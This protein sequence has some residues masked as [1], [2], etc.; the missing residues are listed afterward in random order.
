MRDGSGAEVLVS[1]GG[2]TRRFAVVLA[3]GF[4]SAVPPWVHVGLGKEDAADVE[5]HW[6]GGKVQ[7]LQHL[8]AGSRWTVSEDSQV[9]RQTPFV[10]RADPQR[11]LPPIQLSE[12]GA[13][14][15]PGRTLVAFLSKGCAP[16]KAEIPILNRLA[17]AQ[18]LNII[19]VSTD[20]ED[21]AG[22]DATAKAMGASFK[23]LP[24]TKAASEKMDSL[25][26]LTL[27]LS[28]LYDEQGR[29]TRGLHSLDALDH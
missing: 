17:A 27:P 13:Q 22:A 16:C 24:L 19:G 12:L 1:S 10:K 26:T 20:D 7:T 14:L 25:G 8:E 11:V 2:T 23:V 9:A 3:R 18:S 5:I 28:I 15:K 6:P 4:A 29:W 21:S